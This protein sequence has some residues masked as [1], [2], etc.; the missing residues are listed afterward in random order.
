MRDSLPVFAALLAMSAVAADWPRFRGPNG[1]GVSDT[2]GLPAE[3]GLDKNLIWKTPLPPGHS[4]PI[5]AGDRIF[6]TAYEGDLLL[7]FSLDRATGKVLWRR[8]A[9]RDRKDPVDP[10]NSPASPSPVSD[11]KNVYAFFGDYG[12]VSYGPD[13]NERWRTPLG[14]F[15]NVYGIGVSPV[16][17]DDKIVL[18][19]D[20]SGGSYIAAFGQNDGK[21]RWKVQRPE[22]LS[23]ASTP[24]VMR[25]ANGK[26]LIVA[27]ASF[28][29]DVYSADTGQ[30]VWFMHGLASEMKSVPVIDGD[31]IYIN[32]FNTPENDPG[33]QIAV[34]P[35]DEVLKKFDANHDG[36]I[37][38]DESPDQRTKTLFKYLDLNNDGGLDQHEW[39][40]YSAS[41]AAENSLMAL[42]VPSGG[43]KGDL[44]NS[45]VKWKYHKAV[46]QLPSLVLYRGV[47]YMLND[48]GILTTLNAAT[49]EVLK[50]AR[51]RANSDRYFSSPVAADGKIFIA[52]N[53]GV[54]YVLKAG[55][56]QEQIAANKLDE[57]I[58]ATP[59]IAD[60]RI[61]I[62][63]VAGLY[64]FGEK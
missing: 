47:L 45:V 29:M 35:F 46:P 26:S 40:I 6:V 27:P 19:I 39:T 10:R 63:T 21:V 33:R 52:A 36:K 62:R 44:T 32:G 58:F 18:V 50:A 20:Q 30:I 59:A 4:S 43:A 41:M 22:A 28:R 54:V 8:E 23:G 1:L 17:V 12:M 37:S 9:P 53:S 31:T 55:G 49:G 11:G 7:T 24:S 3:F 14:P 13:G 16:L 25:D 42:S 57:D 38:V 48:S 51:L 5:L 2:T 56:E 60:K 64:C 34:P 15:T 61:Y